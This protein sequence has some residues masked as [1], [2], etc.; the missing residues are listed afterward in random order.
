MF[1]LSMLDAKEKK[2][3]KKKQRKRD[4]KIKQQMAQHGLLPDEQGSQEDDNEP[5][6]WAHN[7]GLFDHLTNQETQDIF[8]KFQREFNDI[9]ETEGDDEN[10]TKKKKTKSGGKLSHEQIRN[11]S[12][13]EL[14]SYIEN[15]GKKLKSAQEETKE[16]QEQSPTVPDSKQIQ[17]MRLKAKAFIAQQTLGQPES[18]KSKPIDP[19]LFTCKFCNGTIEPQTQKFRHEKFCIAN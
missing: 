8:D 19:N 6:H 4:K 13:E 3:L 2:K 5:M 14:F 18:E 16:A 15:E 9:E 1:D 12:T 7:Q 17:Q 10:K 11:L